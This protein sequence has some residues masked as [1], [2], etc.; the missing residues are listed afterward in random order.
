MGKT[1]KRRS[2]FAFLNSYPLWI[3]SPA[4]IP[5][6]CTKI[7]APVEDCEMMAL[8]EVVC[9]QS[10]GSEFRLK[11]GVP[12]RACA[13]NAGPGTRLLGG[14]SEDQILARVR[15]VVS[16]RRP[17]PV[18]VARAVGGPPPSSFTTG[19][20]PQSR[21][22]HRASTTRCGAA[23]GTARRRRRCAQGIPSFGAILPS[24]FAP[25][26]PPALRLFLDE[27]NTCA[28]LGLL[29]EAICRASLHGEPLP[30]WATLVLARVVRV[31]TN[32]DA[33]VQKAYSLVNSNLDV[34][35]ARRCGWVAR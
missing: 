1:V 33:A 3:A 34:A 29:K 19:A 5:H 18:D 11:F 20:L 23:P 6:H 15:K 27:I 9:W 7:Q 26:T 10:M 32:G 30:R 22:P 2:F 14:T 4:P 16:I 35:Q 24:S 31:K 28:H 21:Q 13:G 12:C 25:R 17:H 8:H